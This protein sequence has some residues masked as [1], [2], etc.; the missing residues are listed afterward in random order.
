V[1]HPVSSTNKTDLNDVTE[2]LL[3]VALN[4]IKPKQTKPITVMIM[5]VVNYSFHI[6]IFSIDMIYKKYSLLEI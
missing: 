1:G 6:I 4:V 5:L 3:K 2:I